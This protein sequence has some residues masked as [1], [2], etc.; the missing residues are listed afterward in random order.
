MSKKIRL[1]VLLFV[2]VFADQV[3]LQVGAQ[4]HK[5]T[6]IA[7]VI[8]GKDVPEQVIKT[9]ENDLRFTDQFEPKIS[10][11][12]GALAKSDLKKLSE[13]GFPLAVFI[14]GNEK[15]NA[16]EVRVYNTRKMKMLKGHK[17]AKKGT[18]TRGWGHAL[19]DAVLPLLSGKDGFFSSKIVF[20]KEEGGKKQICIA[21]FDGTHE[22]VLTTAKSKV[23]APRW[24]KD[25]ENPLVL[26]SEYTTLN[27]R[28]MSIDLQGKK[29][30]A[31][32]FDGLNML[33]AFSE[34]GRKVVLCLS[35]KGS[36]QLYEYEY[37]KK[38]GRSVYTALT[39][40]E[41]NN[42][43]PTLLPNGDVVFCSDYEMGTPQIYSLKHKKGTITRLSDGGSCFSPTYS[44]ANNKVAYSQMQEGTAQVMVYDLTTGITTQLTSDAGHKLECSW[45]PCGNYLVF[46]ADE[47]KDRRIA[48][49]SLLTGK[50]R[51]LTASNCRCSYPSWSINYQQ[52][53]QR[54]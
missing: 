1:L 21:D 45:S 12:A 34:D 6:S 35:D 27:V 29:T 43:S 39:D 25:P 31:V 4:S 41:G 33:P 8:L 18:V 26:Y 36:T 50:K 24:N 2:P 52:F 15:E 53:P 51:Y 42:I 44:A 3:Q 37:D 28:L 10:Y 16:F 47:G 46:S 9:V 13:Q 49:Y 40:N 14:N 5:P 7:L 19:A 32:S 30:V 48:S 23:V 11:H 22:Q 20:H 17:V 54:V 38:L